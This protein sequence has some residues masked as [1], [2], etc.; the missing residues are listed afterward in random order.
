MEGFFQDSWKATPK[1]TVE[2]GMRLSH[3]GPWSG[4]N[5]AAAAISGRKPVQQRPE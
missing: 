1:L 5:D 2:L 4:R 3:L